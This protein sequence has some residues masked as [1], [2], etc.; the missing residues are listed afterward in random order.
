M[1]YTL[2]LPHIRTTRTEVNLGADVKLVVSGFTDAFDIDTLSYMETFTFPDLKKVGVSLQNSKYSEKQ[3]EEVIAG[4]K[5]LP[6][7]KRG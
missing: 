1:T 2:P 4:L 6:E 3:I 5:T 7:Y